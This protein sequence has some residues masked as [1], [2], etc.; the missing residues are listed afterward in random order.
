MA[1]VARTS[2]ASGSSHRRAASVSSV[3]LSLEC[4]PPHGPTP[5][6]TPHSLS[7][8]PPR[9][10][11][12]PFLSQA[13]SCHPDVSAAG[14]TLCVSSYPPAPCKCPFTALSTPTADEPWGPPCR[15]PCRRGGGPTLHPL[16]LSP[17]LRPDWPACA[18]SRRELL[19]SRG[20]PGL[21]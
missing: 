3:T 18:D 12:R 21:S 14:T 10:L 19:G 11:Q 2:L 16:H 15:P 7:A 20:P 9:N 8:S 17:G 4:P 5:P 13:G 1:L 6:R